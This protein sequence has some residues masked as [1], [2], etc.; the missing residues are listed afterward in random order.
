M[1]RYALACDVDRQSGLEI[2][3]LHAS[4]PKNAAKSAPGLR[5]SA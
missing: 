5:T 4:P 1:I 3:H 2:G